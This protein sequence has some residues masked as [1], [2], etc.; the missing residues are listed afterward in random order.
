M[1]RPGNPSALADRRAA[2]APPP[3]PPAEDLERLLAGEL[4]DPH[5]VL[6]AHPATSGGTTGVVV[7]A[8][9]P[10]ASAVDLLLADE[11]AIAMTPVQ[12]G[13]FAVFLP[14]RELPLAHRLRFHFAGGDRWERDDPYRFAPTIG[15]LDLH[16]LAEG[17]HRQ[18]WKRLGAHP[19]TVDGVAGTAFAVWAPNAR[20]VSVVGDFN[21]WDGR[22]YPM[23]SMGGDRKSVV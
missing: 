7:R 9:H 2:T 19:R 12:G 13:L 15:E 3:P 16:L 10:D 23:R 5:R 22:V 18:L 11:A 21:G 20:R 14:D 4:P 1:R 17:R 8:Y 6:G